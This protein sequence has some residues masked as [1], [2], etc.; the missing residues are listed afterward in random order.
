MPVRVDLDSGRDQTS[1]EQLRVTVSSDPGWY[2]F[3]TAKAELAYGK[4]VVQVMSGV[5]EMAAPDRV[6]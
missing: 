6:D 5:L 1:P 3:H 2:L 4:R